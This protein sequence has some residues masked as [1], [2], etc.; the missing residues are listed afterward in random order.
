MLQCIIARTSEKNRNHHLVYREMQ[1]VLVTPNG[2]RARSCPWSGKNCAL[3]KGVCRIQSLAASTRPDATK[4]SLLP[5][6]NMDKAFC[7]VSRI[8]NAEAGKELG[9]LVGRYIAAAGM[10]VS[11]GRGVPED[12]KCRG[13]RFEEIGR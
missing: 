8:G 10:M 1:A 2:K 12:A 7:C 13:K 11:F 3:S 5:T 9:T 4:S 6:G